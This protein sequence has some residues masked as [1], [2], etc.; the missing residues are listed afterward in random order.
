MMRD[1]T[2]KPGKLGEA[3]AYYYFGL[4]M[5]CRL[6]EFDSFFRELFEARHRRVRGWLGS[7]ILFRGS[8]S[9]AATYML[10]SGNEATHL[11]NNHT[12]QERETM[13]ITYGQQQTS[14]STDSSNPILFG[15]TSIRHHHRGRILPQEA[16]TKQR[17]SAGQSNSWRETSTLGDFEVASN[18]NINT[19]D[20]RACFL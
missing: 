9:S 6:I 4:C 3:K 13:Q 20:L 19:R 10:L 11:T 7:E 14:L 15:G 8:C 17:H 2:K 1:Q 18:I 12:D 5:D 16:T